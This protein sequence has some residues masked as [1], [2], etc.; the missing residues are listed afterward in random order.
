M[1]PALWIT[2]LC[3]ATLWLTGCLS[4]PYNG[5]PKDIYHQGYQKKVRIMGQN[6]ADA[7]LSG[8]EVDTAR[9][10]QDCQESASLDA[11]ARYGKAILLKCESTE[12]NYAICACEFAVPEE[13]Q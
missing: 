11:R 2:G 4:C 7:S 10:K 9:R 5:I 1:R 6:S 12:G 13:Q 3:A 8:A